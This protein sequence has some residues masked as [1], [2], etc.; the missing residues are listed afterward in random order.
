MADTT[1]P[2]TYTTEPLEHNPLGRPDHHLTQAHT[3][4]LTLQTT[5]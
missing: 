3:L 5:V 2:D 1:I 4:S